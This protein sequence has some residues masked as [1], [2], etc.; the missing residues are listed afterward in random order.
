MG[1]TGSDD[2]KWNKNVSEDKV[3]QDQWM[4]RVSL[5]SLLG[6]E[7]TALSLR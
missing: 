6:K 5:G 3:I 1:W 2:C 4:M 7:K